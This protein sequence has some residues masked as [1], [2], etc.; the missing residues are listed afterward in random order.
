L[1]EYRL[2]VFKKASLCR[3]FENKVFELSK[4]KIINYPVYLSAGQEFIASSLS[5]ICN[6]LGLKPDIFI[7]HRGHSTYLAFGGSIDLLIL[8]LLGDSKGCANGM[9]GSASIQ[10]KEKKIYGHDGLMG[11]QIPIAVGSCFAS[12]NQTIAFVGDSA[13]EEDYVFS[14]IGWAATKKLPI[15]FIIEDNNLS[16]LTEK[17]VR[18]SWEMHNVGK[19]FGIESY[20]ISDDPFEIKKF[21]KK[22]LDKPLLLNINTERKYWHA[23]AGIDGDTFDRYETEM[24]SIGKEAHQ[25][26]QNMKFYIEEEWRKYL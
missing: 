3:H 11:N 19:G 6:D 5:T 25:I 7:Q 26:D 8:E 24:E 14:S 10:C 23:G 4:E 18:R 12:R 16:I 13:A 15:L 9:G 21:I 2:E 1:N 20:N 22:P 17:K